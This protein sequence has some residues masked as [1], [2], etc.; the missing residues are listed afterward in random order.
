MS[1]LPSPPLFRKSGGETVNAVNTRKAQA[2]SQPIF[3]KPKSR[4]LSSQDWFLCKED[5]PDYT[6]TSFR[7]FKWQ[8]GE[9]TIR[10]LYYL[11][12]IA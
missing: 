3:F 6:A 9:K 12:D 2:N 8:Q 1:W 10:Q 4:V 7:A 5:D 11:P